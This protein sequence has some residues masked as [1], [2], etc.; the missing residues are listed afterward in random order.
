MLVRLPQL[1]VGASKL[2][3]EL[4]EPWAIGQQYQGTHL[5]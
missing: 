2:D 5:L 4:Q 1:V 3:S